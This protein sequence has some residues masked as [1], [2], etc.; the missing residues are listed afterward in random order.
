MVCDG[1]QTPKSNIGNVEAIS[2]SGGMQASAQLAP[3]VG[4]HSALLAPRAYKA[5]LNPWSHSPH[6]P[7]LCP[8]L[9]HW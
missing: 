1:R 5:D 4:Y 6:S 8:S 9:D 7:E 3:A 2:L